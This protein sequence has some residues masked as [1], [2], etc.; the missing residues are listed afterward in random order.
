MILDVVLLQSR[1][2]VR[3]RA[4]PGERDR[5]Q[6]LESTPRLARRAPASELDPRP[7]HQQRARR[8]EGLGGR[9]VDEGAEAIR[10]RRAPASVEAA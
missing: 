10:F 9:R 1:L 4:F 2:V 3:R 8:Q 6:L 5:E 7:E